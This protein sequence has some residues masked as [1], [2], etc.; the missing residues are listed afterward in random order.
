[1]NPLKGFWNIRNFR[2]FTVHMNC[3]LLKNVH[4]EPKI[5]QHHLHSQKI[6]IHQK[7]V[8]LV[9][10]SVNTTRVFSIFVL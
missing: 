6:I 5:I 4:E 1:M 10:N 3:A 7:L 8:L 2:L 9:K